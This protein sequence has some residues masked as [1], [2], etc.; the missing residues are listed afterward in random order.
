[1]SPTASSIGRQV[2]GGFW[3]KSE[4]R[5]AP[6]MPNNSEHR[7][8]P[9]VPCSIPATLSLPTSTLDVAILDASRAG[10]RLRIHGAPL[11]LFRASPMSLATAR[12]VALLGKSF[13]GTLLPDRLGSLVT[14]VFRPVRIGLKGCAL[15]DVDVGC[16]FSPPLSDDEVSLLGLAFPLLERDDAESATPVVDGAPTLPSRQTYCPAAPPQVGLNAMATALAQLKAKAGKFKLDS[17][18]PNGR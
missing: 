5:T 18:F 10:A 11:G 9:R 14:K 2:S 7:R 15:P 1:M 12:I 6:R 17:R 13:S 8:A 3:S 16:S 4:G